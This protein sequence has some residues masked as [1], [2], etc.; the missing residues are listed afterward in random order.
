[1]TTVCG[2]YC[3]RSRRSASMPCGVVQPLRTSKVR[4]RSEII[5]LRNGRM[6]TASESPTTST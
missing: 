2:A 1:M 4:R 6:P 5:S 3:C